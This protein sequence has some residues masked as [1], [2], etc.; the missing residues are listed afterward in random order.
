MANQEIFYDK[1]LT[2]KRVMITVDF[3]IYELF[4]GK[5]YQKL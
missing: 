1:L 2:F 5:L 3:Y 4:V